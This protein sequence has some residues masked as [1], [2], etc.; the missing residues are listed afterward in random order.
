MA[1]IWKKRAAAEFSTGSQTAVQEPVAAAPPPEKKIRLIGVAEASS[2]KSPGPPLSPLDRECARLESA[3]DTQTMLLCLAAISDLIELVG[4]RVES[5]IATRLLYLL[6]KDSSLQLGESS[7]TALNSSA[8]KAKLIALLLRLA[9]LKGG[10]LQHMI[11]T[12]VCSLSPQEGSS[13]LCSRSLALLQKLMKSMPNNLAAQKKASEIILP[14]AKKSLFTPDA[15]LKARC[16]QLLGEFGG[17]DSTRLVDGHVDHFDPRVRRAALEALLS[18]HES[19]A[20]LHP[21]MYLRLV[22]GLKDNDERVRMAV[23]EVISLLSRAH[24]DFEVPLAESRSVHREQTIR[25]ADDAFAR[26]CNSVNDLSVQVRAFG[27]KLLG[28]MTDVSEIF[29]E[30]TLDKK[31]MNDMR[32]NSAPHFEQI[33]LE[34]RGRRGKGSFQKRSGGDFRSGRKWADDF[35]KKEGT[36]EAADLTLMSLGACGAFIHG[37]EDECLSVRL[38][39]IES[40]T[41][42]A[43][44]NPSFAHASIDF[45]VEMFNDEIEAVRLRAVHCLRKIGKHIVLRDDQL[46]TILAALEDFSLDIREALHELLSC[47]SLSTKSCLRSTVDALLANLERYPQ[48]RRSLHRCFQWVGRNHPHLTLELVPELL[49]IH[50][51]MDTAEHDLND[52]RYICMLILVFNASASGS[53]IVTL[54]PDYVLRHYSFLRDSMPQLIPY[55]KCDAETGML[56][57]DQ[58]GTPSTSNVSFSG[59]FLKEVVERLNRS[60]NLSFD[61]RQRELTMATTDLLKLGEINRDGA[62]M[63]LAGMVRCVTKLEKSCRAGIWLSSSGSTLQAST[64]AEEI[65]KLTMR[66][67]YQYSNLGDVEKALVAQLQFRACALR[68]LVVVHGS[69]QS[70]LEPCK[71]LLSFL[72]DTHSMFGKLTLTDPL[73]LNLKNEVNK[74]GTTKPK[75]GTIARTLEPLLRSLHCAP[76]R[77]SPQ[78]HSIKETSAIMYEPTGDH[79]L[80]FTAGLILSVPVDCEVQNARTA[81]NLRLQVD[82]PDGTSYLI[83]P[84]PSEIR[85]VASEQNT[86][87]IL[88]KVNVSHKAW[89]D[90]CSIKLSVV[91]D[92]KW[93]G[94]KNRPVLD[95]SGSSSI[96]LC[97][98]VSLDVHP[99]QSRRGI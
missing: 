84:K 20:V 68:F 51:F 27:A 67:E 43:C 50:P 96:P 38:N 48:D 95:T 37:L 10:E 24:P 41:S 4:S 32:K 56:S 80:Q 36:D 73:L 70:A 34:R 3:E 16:L 75:P 59:S 74:L 11:V 15:D 18:L 55:L 17:T 83:S 99:K 8:V 90:I 63:F 66:L 88:A 60:Q 89:T 65:L 21:S 35:P 6:K 53:A 2:P 14:F 13:W 12:E 49:E 98:P 72:E 52:R 22:S 87:R 40:L 19:H 29:L 31:L 61:L 46:E 44:R 5:N 86:F 30:Q 93:S 69:N 57:G 58:S 64:T 62:A 1:A 28:S 92:T 97:Q 94:N 78:T 25:I 82:Y 26:V 45:L 81:D 77:L 9:E 47:C 91:I 7:G 33:R 42:L 71:N 23:L 76:F 39:S 85:P 79:V 54:L